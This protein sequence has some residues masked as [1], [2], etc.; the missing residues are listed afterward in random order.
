MTFREYIKSTRKPQGQAAHELGITQATVSR[1]AGGDLPSL[2]LAVRIE[3]WSDGKV[4]P[5]DFI[6]ESALDAF[7]N[8]NDAEEPPLLAYIEECEREGAP[9]ELA[10]GNA[11]VVTPH[12]GAGVGLLALCLLI[13]PKGAGLFQAVYSSALWFHG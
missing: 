9:I 7:Q 4:Q 11:S 2:M 6:S 13:L 3:I 10:R 8:G 1:I 12:T 5:R